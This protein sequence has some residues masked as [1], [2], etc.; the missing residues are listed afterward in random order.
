ML[1]RLP[2][3]NEQTNNNNNN[4]NK[5]DRAFYSL[6]NDFLLC[7]AQTG[8]AEERRDFRKEWGVW[9][10]LHPPC[11]VNAIL[12][13]TCFPQVVFDALPLAGFSLSSYNAI[14]YATCETTPERVLDGRHTWR[15]QRPLTHTRKVL[16][17]RPV[18][19]T[20]ALSSDLER[21]QP[22]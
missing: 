21:W 6:R 8:Q 3:K 15:V 18:V 12:A 17:A 2:V 5:N 22:H 20:Y 19:G 11:Q 4:N 7:E 16:S 9:P 1:K 14:L 13:W 10:R